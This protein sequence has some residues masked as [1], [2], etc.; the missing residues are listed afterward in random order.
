MQK[1]KKLSDIFITMALTL[2]MI[3]GLFAATPLTAFA[4]TIG[5]YKDV[6]ESDWFSGDVRY[7]YNGGLMDAKGGGFSPSVATTRGELIEAMY[8]LEGKPAVNAKVVFSDLPASSPYFNSV[9]WTY[10]KGV[11]KGYGN[12]KIGTADKIT[13]E[14]MVT[15]LYR[16]AKARG[17]DVS[18]R[19]DL[20]RYADKSTVSK[21]AIEAFS[22]A[23]STGLIT[24]T[25]ETALTPR[26]TTTRAQ[27]AAVTHRFGEKLLGISYN[28]D[29]FISSKKTRYVPTRVDEFSPMRETYYNYDEHT[30]KYLGKKVG[31][32]DRGRSITAWCK[33][34]ELDKITLLEYFDKPN[35]KYINLTCLYDGNS[36]LARVVNNITGEDTFYTSTFDSKGR[37]ISCT[38]VEV[39]D[40]IRISFWAAN[41]EYLANGG[42]N[43]IRMY[44]NR[45]IEGMYGSD[46][47]LKMEAEYLDGK[48][49]KKTTCLYDGASRVFE[50]T[51]VEPERLNNYLMKYTYDDDGNLT[52][53]RMK[54][55][56]LGKNINADLRYK[57]EYWKNYLDNKRV[58]YHE[59]DR[60]EVYDKNGY[61]NEAFMEFYTMT[62]P[63]NYIEI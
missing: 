59:L 20:S 12:G 49:I 55:T 23:V 40:L 44:E 5:T 18:G 34:N 42:Y 27:V 21:W 16:F 58:L 54:G 31:V 8:R 35:D 47:K 26:G 24:G 39:D 53:I 17:E 48:L 33:Y 38:E 28:E 11:I 1:C 61:N 14:Q 51:V 41:Y 22:W 45:K 15:M 4:D 46:G 60:L 3:C 63:S 19:A 57:I 50:K 25:S 7:V 32:G 62:C 37:V 13:R 30:K 43:R 29:K 2:A 36:Q 10:E 56:Y 9:S 52:V 6:Y